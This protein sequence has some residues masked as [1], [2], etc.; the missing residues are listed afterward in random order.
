[1]LT[2]KPLSELA[3]RVN[4]FPQVVK[5]VEVSQKRDFSEVPEIEKALRAGETKL[6]S[7]G[8]LLVRYSGTQA[9]CRIMAEGDNEDQV[10]LVVEM[11]ADAIIRHL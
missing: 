5:N 9:M 1:M 7:T 3:A 10:R 6:G 2:G 4:K 11:V 8:R